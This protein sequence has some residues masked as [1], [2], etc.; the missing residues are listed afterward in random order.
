MS[1]ECLVALPYKTSD[2]D[3]KVRFSFHP[4][5]PLIQLNLT[6]A[7]G[8]PATLPL[9]QLSLNSSSALAGSGYLDITSSVPEFTP[10]TESSTLTKSGG[11]LTLVSGQSH[12]L[13]ML[14]L[15][16]EHEELN[17][18][19]VA[20]DN[21]ICEITVPGVKLLPGHNYLCDLTV[22]YADF[23]GQDPLDVIPSSLSVV[24]GEPLLF[25]IEGTAGSIEFWSGETYHSFEYADKDRVEVTPLPMSFKHALVA[26]TQKSQPRVQVSSDF[27]GTMDETA[28][29]AASWTDITDKFSFATTVPGDANPVSNMTNYDLYFKDAGEYDICGLMQETDS[30]YVGLFWHADKYDAALV[31]T[32]TASWFTCLKVGDWE[33]G[34]D[35]LSL[36]WNADKW[37]GVSAS[38]VPKWMDPNTANGVPANPVFRFMSE[39]RPTA[40]RDAYAV[41]NEAFKKKAV[42]HGHDTP[43]SVKGLTEDTPASYS[44]AFA[45]AGTYEVYFIG[46]SSKLDGSEDTV[47]KQFTITVNEE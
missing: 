27:D 18:K 25:T 23:T 8:G 44:Y 24:K 38:Y 4:F 1:E 10:L 17:L 29:L 46:R 22:D 2:T 11:V 39:F 6:L 31:N 19:L 37:S 32:R 28:I 12:S 16:G 3:S 21:S 34:P 5:Y 36:V 43:C 14:A 35:N 15:P 7:V 47:I 33:M 13:Y 45:E 26:G 42:N 30:L 20:S 41:T 9:T 40:D